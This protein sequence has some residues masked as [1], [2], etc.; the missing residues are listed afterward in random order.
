MEQRKKLLQRIATA[1]A[2]KVNSATLRVAID[3]VD[4]AGKSTFA[5]ELWVMLC[6]EGVRIIRASLDGFHNPKIIRYR[7]GRYSPEGFYHDSYDYEALKRLLL[8]PLAPAGSGVYT[9][10]VFNHVMDRPVVVSPR[11]ANRGDVLLFD[12]IFLQRP[13]LRGYWDLSLYLDIR[14]DTSVSRLQQRDSGPCS[15]DHPLNR[16][17]TDGQAFYRQRCHPMEKA[18]IIVD[19]NEVDRPFI[20]KWDDRSLD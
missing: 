14:S 4:G 13:E 15:P 9:T 12:G 19:N 5:D 20:V 11:E 17:Y 7:K 10:A 1:I 2:N 16:R 8:D 3:G 18:H 6:G